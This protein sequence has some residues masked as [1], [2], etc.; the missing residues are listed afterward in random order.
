MGQQWAVVR[1]GEVLTQTTDSVPVDPS[2]K[3]PNFGI[4]S[5]GRGLFGKAPIDGQNTSAT[6]LYRVRSGQIVYSRLFAFE[7]AYGV[8]PPEFDGWY[9]SNEYPTFNCDSARL[10]PEF[11]GLFLRRRHV[12]REIA[13]GSKGLGDRRQRVQPAQLLRFN[14][15]LPSPLEQG[16]I[17]ARIE[18]LALRIGEAARL[19]ES[20]RIEAGVLSST[21]AASLLP[22]LGPQSKKTLGDL[23]SIRGGGTPDKSNP[24]FWSG[25]IP[26]I[27][28]KDM[29]HRRLCDSID[30][31]SED[32]TRASPAKVLPTGSVLVVVRG[33]ILAHTVPVA[34]LDSPAT[35]NQDIKALVPRPEITGAYLT[36]VL[37]AL[38][39]QLLELVEKSTHDTRK[40]QTDALLRFEIPVPPL[41]EQHRIVA[42][43]DDLQA[44]VDALKTLQGKTAAEL[45]ALMPSIL[46]KA[47]R[48]EL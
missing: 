18:A 16:R 41:R 15:A 4:Y 29:K 28:P 38:N 5:F 30:H 11:L 47:F 17:V 7:G 46:D 22:T 34:L 20:V 48:G 24:F 36:A 44:K 9:I 26:W 37:W 21:A 27:S 43:L 3:Y 14:V 42:R 19:R 32:A 13:V 25:S 1:L 33:M 6:T 40:L 12:W 2:Q 8:V 45:G 31:I 39:Q 35:I 23:V 10:S